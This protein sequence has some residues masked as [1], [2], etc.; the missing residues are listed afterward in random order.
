MKKTFKYV[1]VLSV[2]VMAFATLTLTGCKEDSQYIT[3]GDSDEIYVT[4]A[5][6]GSTETELFVT[7]NGYIGANYATSLTYD[8]YTN[9]E[10]WEIV[11]DYSDCFEPRH[12]WVKIW[13]SKGN[14]DGRF[15]ISFVQNVVQGDT[16]NVKINVVSKGQII[17]T[18]TAAQDG[19]TL[20]FFIQP[21][22]TIQ[23]FD[24]N[25]TKAKSVSVT[26]NVKWNVRVN[27]G[28]DGLPVEWVHVAIPSDSN[29]NFNITCDPNTTGF[30][31]EATLTV[32]QESDVN[33]YK[34]VTV[35]QA[36]ES[37][38]E[39]P[40]EPTPEEPTPGEG[41]GEGG[42]NTGGEGTEG[43][44]NAGGESTEGGETTGGENA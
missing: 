18:I 31:R 23:N 7:E 28:E 15:T 3:Y 35:K 43:G 21:F 6:T 9:A 30:D 13:P 29:S 36:A 1:K 27:D 12:N 34:I 19:F 17:K 4:F 32:Y 11:P 39:V 10:E 8:M 20:S 5:G 2:A 22:L 16:R 44:E 24:W 42:E 33:N 41:E 40:E 14:Y 37:F 38:E 26:S 25:P